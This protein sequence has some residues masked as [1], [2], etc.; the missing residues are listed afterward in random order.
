MCALRFQHEEELQAVRAELETMRLSSQ[1]PQPTSQ[2]V[3]PAQQPVQLAE[4]PN[5]QPDSQTVQQ[6]T[7]QQETSPLPKPLTS[8]PPILALAPILAPEKKRKKKKPQKIKR[9]NEQYKNDIQSI[10]SALLRLNEEIQSQ[11]FLSYIPQ[12]S[13]PFR[14]PPTIFPI[15]SSPPRARIPPGIY[16]GIVPLM[17][18][19]FL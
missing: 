9:K 2:H 17:D 11:D 14:Q 10:T 6:L 3:Q 7:S 16:P 12:I 1:N 8:S 15:S 5:P 18:I 19:L 13:Y 4:P